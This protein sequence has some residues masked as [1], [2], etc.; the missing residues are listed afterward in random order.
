MPPPRLSPPPALRDT[1]KAAQDHTD[2]IL[3]ELRLEKKTG[4]LPSG[5]VFSYLERGSGNAKHTL[6]C[7]HGMTGVPHDQAM[8][9]ADWPALSSGDVRCIF[10][11][12]MGQW[13]TAAGSDAGHELHGL[14]L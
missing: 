12:A 14:W 11:D 13:G 4:V 7:L 2:K 8:L 5:E 3:S 9:M 10:P 1:V 6:V